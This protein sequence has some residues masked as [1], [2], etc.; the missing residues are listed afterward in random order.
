MKNLD[1]AAG[2]SLP[3][4]QSTRRRTPQVIAHRGYKRLY[5]ENTLLAFR[6]AL[7]PGGH[8]CDGIET[9][10]HVS[11]DGVVVL[12]HDS[13][14]KR[15][16]GEEGNVVAWPWHAPSGGKALDS[17]RT[18]AEPHVGMPRL[19]DALAMLEEDAF[20][21]RWL[22]L[23]IKLS[24]HVDV[25]GRIAHVLKGTQG[26]LQYWQDRIVLGIWHD[27][28]LS[29]CRQHL[30]TF[31]IT[32]IGLHTSY[33]S[34]KFLHNKAVTSFNMQL[35]ALACPAGEQFV[36]EAH[37]LG[38][39]VF[40]WTAND[41]DWIRYCQHI[42][43]LDALLTDDP[44]LCCSLVDNHTTAGTSATFDT[45][46]F[47]TQK[48]RWTAWFWRN[49]LYLIMLARIYWIYRDTSGKKKRKNGL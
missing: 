38:K 11:A 5:P 44:A 7:G 37:A 46:V 34:R 25:I 10:V 18:V 1:G 28:F 22:L 23:D 43:H 40:V 31:A 16:F 27:K 45:A 41:V 6:E 12:S 14:L 32:H 20:K 39:Q 13:N 33:A 36:R 24:N 19:V 26:G 49:V 35:Y 29:H 2:S 30:D 42:L 15:C 8:H 3:S 48:R 17:L 9:D 47:W 4:S 21:D